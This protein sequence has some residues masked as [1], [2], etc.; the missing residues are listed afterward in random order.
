VTFNHQAYFIQMPFIAASG[1]SS[2]GRK[3]GVA[4]KG[5]VAKNTVGSKNQILD[6]T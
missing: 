3:V 1:T 5:S 6:T 4:V 2:D